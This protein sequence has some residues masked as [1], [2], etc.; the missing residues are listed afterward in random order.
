MGAAFPLRSSLHAS[1][2]KMQGRGLRVRL[3]RGPRLGP[4]FRGLWDLLPV[5]TRP[6]GASSP[7][8]GAVGG[9]QHPSVREWV[10]SRSQRAFPHVLPTRACSYC[11]TAARG[12]LDAWPWRG[13]SCA[14]GYG[15]PRSA[16]AGV[17]RGG[18]FV[19]RAQSPGL[20]FVASV[21]LHYLLLPRTSLYA[22]NKQYRS[23]LAIACNLI[24]F[25]LAASGRGREVRGGRANF[26][27]CGVWGKEKGLLLSKRK[28]K[29]KKK[30]KE[31]K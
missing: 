6:V 19:L 27:P 13:V 17:R 15:A 1:P 14:V 21:V 10:C 8:G 23:T 12:H 26:G 30:E 31:G 18:C 22:V 28:R 11:R 5:S 9:R 29:K 24:V 16:A 3:F 7:P 20:G 2:G 25:V 4:L